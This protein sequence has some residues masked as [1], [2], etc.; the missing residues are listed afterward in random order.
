MELLQTFDE[1]LNLRYKPLETEFM[2]KVGRNLSKEVSTIRKF[3]LEEWQKALA[4]ACEIQQKEN[5]ICAY[6]SISFL[7]T[8][9]ID[10]KPT[11]QIDFYNEEWVYGEAWARY[12]M[13]ADFLFKYWKDFKFDALDDR[14]FIRS[15]ISKV[16][17]KPL[18][19]GTLDK[20]T[21][22]FTCYAKYF[23][24]RLVYYS[25]FDEL[26]KAENFY[27]TC[28]TYL[29][30]QNRICAMLPEIDLLNPDANEETNFRPVK[31]K[32]YRH[33]KFS[34]L[35]LRGCQ[36]VDCRF[37]NFTFENLKLTDAIFLNCRFTSTKF[38]NVKMAGCD[39]FEC[40]FKNCTFENCTSSP[41]DVAEDNDEYFAPMRMYHCFL[42]QINID[43]SCNFDE[44]IKIDC[45]EK[46]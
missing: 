2:K 42:L 12:R 22:L 38:V 31:K 36:F 29:D 46:E 1:Y 24:R 4:Y 9:L 27:V 30:W 39:L 16:E 25:E 11:F 26:I 14:F 6:M 23:A 20:L 18:F 7:N 19:W 10:D 34:D 5:K 33:K 37:D 15:K 45:Y 17:I 8:S 3:C 43:E 41:A 40:Y 32:I 28:G 44:W 13:S 21:F 35:D